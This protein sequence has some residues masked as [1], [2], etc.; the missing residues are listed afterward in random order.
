M[1]IK[2]ETDVDA[3]HPDKWFCPYEIHFIFRR[4]NDRTEWLGQKLIFDPQGNV[5]SLRSQAIKQIMT[6]EFYMDLLGCPLNGPPRGAWIIIDYKVEQKELLADPEHCSPLFGAMYGSNY[7]S[8]AELLGESANL[9]LRKEQENISGVSCY[10]LEGTTKY[11]KVTAWVAPEK[12]YSA[13]KWMVHKT[14]GDLFDERPISDL[15]INSWLAV[16]DSVEVQ[17]VNDAFVTIGGC[18]THTI[19]FADR[20]K[21]VSYRKYKVSEV[22]INPDFEALGA[23]KINLPDGTKVYV[24]ERQSIR[25]IWQDGKIVPAGDPTF[26]EIDKMVEE[27]KKEQ[28]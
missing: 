18:L 26:N 17:K 9:H 3:N 6:G 8:V 4:D 28:Q 15:N 23:F 25:Y 22:E 2:M 13:L 27:L 11:G 12:G 1:E 20:R 5:D 16:F 14:N 19:N 10:V 24:K 7:K 21:R